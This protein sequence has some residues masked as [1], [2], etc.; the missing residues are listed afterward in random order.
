LVFWVF[1]TPGKKIPVL[2]QSEL[3][4][5]SVGKTNIHFYHISIIPS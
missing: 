2:V 4:N 5:G 1:L 3:L